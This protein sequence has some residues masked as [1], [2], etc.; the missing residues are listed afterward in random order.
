MNVA[1]QE[2]YHDANFEFEMIIP[3]QS[4]SQL[5]GAQKVR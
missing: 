5:P 3:L 2:K 1:D 4:A